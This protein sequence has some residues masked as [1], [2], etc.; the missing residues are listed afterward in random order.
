MLMYTPSKTLME[1]SVD[2]FLVNTNIICVLDFEDTRNHVEIRVV[3]FLMH[4]NVTS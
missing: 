4:V 1:K 3:S 2:K